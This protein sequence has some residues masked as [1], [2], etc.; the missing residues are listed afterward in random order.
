[1]EV[2][3]QVQALVKDHA[4]TIGLGLL[5]AVILAGVAW[6]SMSRVSS[7]S[8]AALVNQARVNEASMNSNEVPIEQEEAEHQ[9]DVMQQVQ[10]DM[11]AQAQTDNE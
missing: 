5:V 6:Y 4:L 10:G 8:K 11:N 2:L 7:V 9:S 3:G 1:M